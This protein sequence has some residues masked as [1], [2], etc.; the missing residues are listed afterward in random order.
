MDPDIWVLEIEVL[1]GRHMLDDTT[2]SR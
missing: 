1:N 2:L